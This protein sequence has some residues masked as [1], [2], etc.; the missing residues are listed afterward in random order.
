MIIHHQP[1]FRDFI[2][3][4]LK[5]KKQ[6]INS[7]LTVLD[8]TLGE[9]GHSLAFLQENCQ[10]WG[11]DRDRQ[12]LSKAKKRLKEFPFF[13]PVLG[14]F[15]KLDESVL[16]ESKFDIILLDL[17][18]SKF[19]YF[20]SGRGFSFANDEP[21]DMC[22]DEKVEGEKKITAFNVVNEFST[23]KLLEIFT[24]FGEEDWKI[25]KKCSEEI[26][27][28]RKIAPLKKTGELVAIIKNAYGLKAKKIKI[29]PATKIFQAL[30]IYLNDE[31]ALLPEGIITA[32]KRL[33]QQGILW[34]I[35]YHSLEDR[36]VKNTFKEFAKKNENYN[37]YKATRKKNS[38]LLYNKK[39]IK[40]SLDEIKQNPA[41]RS[42]K[43][44]GIIKN[45]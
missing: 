30:R 43:L 36:I 34:V 25:A 18:I 33:K 1:V 45:D 29:H 41:A 7:P 37:K 9:G 22:L 32:I 21:L 4:S 26:V 35:T 5:E 27:F 17:G 16:A 38:F 2:I 8:A 14:N 40:A 20:E 12:V 44:R 24:K 31:L 39:V 28:K 11:L 3:N 42:A 13:T 23:K 10:V 19:H 6:G 15:A